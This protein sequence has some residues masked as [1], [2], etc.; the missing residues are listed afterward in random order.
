MAL[1]RSLRL[2]TTVWIIA[3]VAVNVRTLVRPDSHTTFPVLAGSVEHWWADQPLYAEYKPL[4]YFRYPPPFPVFFS[5]LAL[6]GPRAGGVLW[7]WLSLAAYGAGLWVFARYVL[8][9]RWSDARLAV[10]LVLGLIGGTRGLWNG[11]SNAFVVGLLL[12]GTAA[13]VQ[14]RWWLAAFLLGGATMVKLTP[15]APVLLL[16][17]LWP[18]RLTLPFVAA[19]AVYA[20]VPFLTRPPAVVVDHYRE[21]AQHLRETSRERWPGFR[22]AYTVWQVTRQS[23]AGVKGIPW[24]REPLDA[25]LYRALQ[26]LAALAALVWSQRLRRQLVTEREVVTRTL[27]AGLAWLMLFGPAVEHAGYAFLAPVLCWAFLESGRG[28]GRRAL[29]GTAFGLVMVL[30]WGSLTRSLLDALPVLLAALPVGTALFAVWLVLPDSRIADAGDR[31]VHFAHHCR[32]GFAH[33]LAVRRA[34]E[35]AGRR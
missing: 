7:A 11:Q 18:R 32:A 35:F 17:T 9:V 1:S 21:W 31:R 26:L 27:A 10:Y 30:G 23:L 14:R 16:C 4:D 13:V 20:A 12:L 33:R 25:P 5:P 15:I 22:D 29:I 28:M 8:P 3:G 34:A 6:L 2:A 19:L 24:L